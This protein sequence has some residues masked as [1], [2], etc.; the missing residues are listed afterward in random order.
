VAS[1][2]PDWKDITPEELYPAIEQIRRT[3]ELSYF[4]CSDITQKL[5]YADLHPQETDARAAAAEYVPVFL[6]YRSLLGH[7]ARLE[8]DVLLRGGTPSGIFKAYF[9]AFCKGMETEVHRVFKELLKIG[10]ANGKNLRLHPVE[11][12]KTH[13]KMMIASKSRVVGHWIKE[14]CDKQI[15]SKPIET[16]QD[17]EEEIF[18]RTWRAPKLVYMRPSGPN[19]PYNAETAWNREDEPRTRKLLEGF[20]EKFVDA[21]EFSLKETA[22]EAYIQ[23]AKEGKSQVRKPH[24]APSPRANTPRPPGQVSSGYPQEFS[25]QARALVEAE[26]LRARRELAEARNQVSSTYGPAHRI[27]RTLEDTSSECGWCLAGRHA[28]W[29]RSVSGMLTKSAHRQMS[30]SGDSRSKP[31]ITMDTIRMAISFLRW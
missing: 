14:V 3:F 26:K 8:F 31:T 11:W 7:Q 2:L 19:F 9:D 27:V 16:K 18:W 23:L 21:L 5:C 20:S 28:N 17:F 13:L 24:E 4:K 1:K 6:L 10:L 12:T 22:G 29:A 30:F 25:R 15:R